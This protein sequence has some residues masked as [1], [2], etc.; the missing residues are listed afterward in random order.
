MIAT[1]AQKPARLMTDTP[2][3][4]VSTEPPAAAPALLSP[5]AEPTALEPGAVQSPVAAP[6]APKQ[7]PP[8]SGKPAGRR[9]QPA[10][11]A[12]QRPP[13]S[14]PLLEKLAALY[15]QLFGENFLPLKRGIFQDLLAAHPQELEAA[16]LKEAMAIH[17]RSTR[18][19]TVVASG[20][21][22]HDL[23][24]Q[25]VEDMAPEHIYQAL[26]EVFR[27]R[28]NRT[29][30]DLRDKL[31]QRIIQAFDQSG[32]SLADYGER[33]RSRDEAANAVLDAALAELAT[34]AARD[35][36]LLRAF[37]ASGQSVEAFANMYGMQPKLAAQA[38]E[39]ARRPRPAAAVPAAAPADPVDEAAVEAPAAADAS[40]DA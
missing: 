4:P 23:K 30:E 24:G 26:L 39:R 5:S 38:L 19:L 8:R 14:H 12:S 20:L 40:G 25:P 27:R 6:A 15:P 9:P 7:R 28:H 36:A 21:Q 31:R 18:Y 22:R 1:F 32:M 37:E 17:A 11:P 16:A 35:E 3:P 33:M 13:R 34:R 2:E 10:A 29:G